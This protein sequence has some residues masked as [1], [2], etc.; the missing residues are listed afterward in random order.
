MKPSLEM[1]LRSKSSPQNQKAHRSL[2]GPFADRI[3]PL[4]IDVVQ[5]SIGTQKIEALD[6]VGVAN[7]PE[8]D[9]FKTQLMANF[10]HN[11]LGFRVLPTRWR[12]FRLI[13][14]L[15]LISY[16]EVRI[17]LRQCLIVLLQ[18]LRS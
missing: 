4:K 7:L 10:S 5:P 13:M 3:I 16:Y 14:V 11:G 1:R 18:P 12:I 8:I 6:D 17:C 15:I 2:S 9:S